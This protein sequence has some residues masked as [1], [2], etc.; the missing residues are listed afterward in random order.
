MYEE[1]ILNIKDYYAFRVKKGGLKY[2]L[3]ITSSGYPRVL[4]L[5]V[6]MH[7]TKQIV[8]CKVFNWKLR[9]KH[10]R[11]HANGLRHTSKIGYVMNPYGI[12]R[13]HL[14]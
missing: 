13:G 4:S 3:S 2:L 9:L 11:G 12:L 10:E 14:Y 8:I 7:D 5:G 1:L 6:C